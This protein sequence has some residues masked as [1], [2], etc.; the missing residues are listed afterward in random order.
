[1]LAPLVAQLLDRS[2]GPEQTGDFQ[3]SPTAF[4]ILLLA[5]FAVGTLGHI[6]KSK[7][8]VATGVLMIFLATVAIP[9]ALHLTR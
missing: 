2:R 1:M 7:T 8:M 3:V 5:G 4:V 6:Y 9:L